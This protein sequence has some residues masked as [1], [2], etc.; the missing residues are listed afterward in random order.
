MRGR[1]GISVAGH[2]GELLQGRVGPGGPV[3]LVTLPCPVLVCRAA[4]VDGS[5]GLYQTGNR[6]LRP[7]DLRLLLAALGHPIRGRFRLGTQMPVGAGTGASTAS[8]VALAIAAGEEDPWRIARACLALEGA[9]DPLMFAAPA[10]MLW[11]SREARLL[12]ALPPL[13]KLEIL[14]GFFGPPRRT[15]PG[16]ANFPDIGDL[17]QGW[18]ARAGDLPAL[19]GLASQS[20]L[21]CLA[22]RGPAGDPTEAL[23]RRL[24]AAGF[25]LAH[26]GSARALLFA[27]GTIPP[28]AGKDLQAA[29]F[30]GITRYS[31]AG[32]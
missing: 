7:A 18:K 20:A 16:D 14:G 4:R 24:G 25:A 26:T 29:G 6:A 5:F 23:A 17:V 12:E 10:Q 32:T 31:L 21:R 1:T 30:S 8:R 3:A 9:S 15:D 28:Q 13:P 27:P 22:L 11:A 2:F 19:A